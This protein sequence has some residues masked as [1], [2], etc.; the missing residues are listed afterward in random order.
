MLWLPL[1]TELTCHLWFKHTHI[2][3]HNSNTPCTTEIFEFAQFLFRMLLILSFLN[4]IHNFENIPYFRLRYSSLFRQTQHGSMWT[5]SEHLL[6]YPEAW[7]SPL[8][9]V[10]TKFL[11][12]QKNSILQ[13]QPI[14]LALS[15]LVYHTMH[16]EYFRLQCQ[17]GNEKITN[18]FYGK[19]LLI[20]NEVTLTFKRVTLENCQN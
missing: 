17:T 12:A 3:I 1:S 10:L 20:K 5:S 4:S 19:L 2:L 15:G 6:P 18:K 8:L 14:H 7:M 16:R 11:V 13:Q 9:V